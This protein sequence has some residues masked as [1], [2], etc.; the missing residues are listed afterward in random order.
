M[1]FNFPPL[2]ASWRA[3]RWRSAIAEAEELFTDGFRW[4]T[5]ALGNH[6]Q[7]RQATRYG[8]ERNARAAAVLL[9]TLRGT[10]FL[11][12]G[13][14]LGLTDAD[15]PNDRVV[16]PGGRDGCRAPL[17]WDARAP[18]GWGP[19]PWLPFPPD[20]EERSVERQRGDESSIL[21]LYRRLL[22]ARRNSPALAVGTL[23]LLDAPDDVVLYRR[24]LDGDERLVAIHFGDAPAELDLPA[25][26]VEVASDGSGEG[27]LFPGT[28]APGLAVLLR[29]G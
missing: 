21:Y 9:L 24:T 14:E 16:D 22:S 13:E 20:A 3:D 28:L 4:P 19:E 17:P 11:Y 15:V 6:D 18:H 26:R 2:F 8:S 23:E 25:H 7:E 12:N 1:V 29:P 5:W 10:P 27:E